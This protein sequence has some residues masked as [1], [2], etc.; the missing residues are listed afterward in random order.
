MAISVIATIVINFIS[1]IKLYYAS[2]DKIKARRALNYTGCIPSIRIIHA[3]DIKQ[4]KLKAEERCGSGNA[5]T[6]KM[7]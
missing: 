3:Q 4:H 5:V 1:M 6:R 7:A 2:I